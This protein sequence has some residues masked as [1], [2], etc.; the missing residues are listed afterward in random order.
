MKYYIIL[1]FTFFGF[2]L[3]S[4]VTTFNQ[5]ILTKGNGSVEDVYYKKK[6]YIID[7]KG[8]INIYSSSNKSD[9]MSLTADDFLKFESNNKN[10][11]II[12]AKV[13]D[14]DR[15]K[16]V[17]LRMLIE[18]DFSLYEYVDN[19]GEKIYVVKS[20][21][22]Y[23]VLERDTK[24]M[25]NTNY[26]KWLYENLNPNG[27]DVA[28]YAPIKYNREDL[29]TY[30]VVNQNNAVSLR[31]EETV[32]AFNLFILT[33]ILRNNV[34]GDLLEVE[35]I[36]STSMKLGFH[37]VVNLDLVKENNSLIGGLN[38]YSNSGGNGS[39]VIRP[40]SQFN[41]ERINT[42][43]E[44]RFMSIYFGYQYNFHINKFSISPYLSFEPMFFVADRSFKVTSQEEDGYADF[45]TES[46]SGN[47]YN[48]N[49]GI[50]LASFQNFILLFEYSLP[51]TK[52]S[53]KQTLNLRTIS[54]D[55]EISRISFSL[56]Y[57]LL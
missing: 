38:Y 24:S 41:S 51:L 9:R 3:Q 37:A 14:I 32:K 40:E 33:G 16:K 49:L 48:F 7:Q 11:V 46:F 12:S 42:E 52:V 54:H 15:N 53:A 43:V 39:S 10:I 1:I 30:F 31:Q 5:G 34:S 19:Q 8:D 44:F 6:D 27:I 29:V 35:E 50:K 55:L 26:K 2:A 28:S 21:D 47:P 56:G 20:R 36:T 17:L 4:Q 18:G 13:I 45:S 22:N 57:K 23:M 25:N